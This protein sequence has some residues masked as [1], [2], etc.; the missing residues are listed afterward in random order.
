MH[1]VYHRLSQL[2]WTCL[3]L[4]HMMKYSTPVSWLR[5]I[6]WSCLMGRYQIALFSLLYIIMTSVA[7]F[8][9]SDIEHC[10]LI[11]APITL[12]LC[13]A[14]SPVPKCYF[15]FLQLGQDQVQRCQKRV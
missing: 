14:P 12:N 6:H 10:L 15:F 8:L 4:W 1:A 7:V 11:A 3:C 13:L 9:H 2:I 5:L